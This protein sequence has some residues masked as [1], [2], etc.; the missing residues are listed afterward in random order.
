MNN[1]LTKD[2]LFDVK[3]VILGQFSHDSDMEYELLTLHACAANLAK[4]IEMLINNTAKSGDSQL[5]QKQYEMLK[6]DHES[7]VAKIEKTE[8]DMSEKRRKYAAISEFFKALE[9]LEQSALSFSED[10]WCSLVDKAVVS[11][12][13]ITFVFKDGSEETL[14]IKF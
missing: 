9:E 8:N 2:D 11:T 1:L 3:N 14:P 10:L 4:Q 5:F 7:V 6:S 13:T 12:D